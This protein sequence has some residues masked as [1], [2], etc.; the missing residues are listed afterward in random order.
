MSR[1]LPPPDYLGEIVE[2]IE[3]ASPIQTR[4]DMNM[5]V[6]EKNVAMPRS[7]KAARRAQYATLVN[8][9]VGESFVLDENV[10]KANTVTAAGRI[11]GV[12]LHQRRMHDGTLRLFCMENKNK[13]TTF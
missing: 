5:F 7:G 12:K 6:I 13:L 11:R 8:M 2:T 10:Y 3:T 1:Y 9:D 4:E